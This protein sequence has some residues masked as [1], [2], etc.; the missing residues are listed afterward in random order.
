[1][2]PNLPVSQN[3]EQAPV[4]EISPAAVS[5]VLPKKTSHKA[6]KIIGIVF[7]SL[8]LILIL[9][10]WI[11]SKAPNLPATTTNST[12][13]GAT[14][15]A[16]EILGFKTTANDPTGDYFTGD[17][18]AQKAIVDQFVKDNS[19][20]DSVY[21]Y[22]AANTAFKIDDIKDAGF[23]FFAAQ[24]RKAFDYKR[25]G[26]GDADGNN[27]QTYIGFLNQTVG[28]QI[29]PAITHDPA[30]FSAAVSMLESWNVI[31]TDDTIYKQNGYGAYAVSQAQWADLANTAK[32]DYLK[33]YGYKIR[34]FINV[35]KNSEAW[36]FVSDYNLGKISHT[37]ENAALYQQDLD[38]VNKGL[39]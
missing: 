19:A 31:P 38:L 21:L 29:N 28:Q 1:M 32:S 36:N 24:V 13:K 2:E 20:S 14:L 10:A 3:Q 30:T 8:V 12:N 37:P 33:N 23:L 5:P 35:P 18:Q 27:V 16:Q 34:D 11:G 9:L 25:Y 39:Q 6:L 26:L 15:T 4:P 22:M 17:A 7:G